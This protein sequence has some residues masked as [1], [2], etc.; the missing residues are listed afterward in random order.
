MIPILDIGSRCISC[1]NCTQICPE[2]A[3]FIKNN[4]YSIDNR[5]CTLCQ[6]CLEVC[7]IDC[8]RL[9]VDDSSKKDT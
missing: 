3:I 8:I 6:L 4:E 9:L 5:S 7:P 1:D 2:N